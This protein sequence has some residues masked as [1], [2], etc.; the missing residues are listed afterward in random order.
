MSFKNWLAVALLLLA[1]PSQ[2]THLL[3]GEMS[4]RYLGAAAT[5][6]NFRY[7]VTVLVYVNANADP[8]IAEG[9]ATIEV[10]FYSKTAPGNLLRAVTIPRNSFHSATP[11]VPNCPG[12]APA[13]PVNVAKYVAVVE[14]PASFDGYY[15]FYTDSARNLGITN[16]APNPNSGVGGASGN[17]TLYLDMAPPL[18]PNASPIF[19]DTAVAVICQ[20]D[21]SIIINNAIDPDGDRL[22]YSFGTPSGGNYGPPGAPV[23]GHFT[24]PPP[25]INYAGGYSVTQ[26]FGPGPGNFAALNANTGISQYAARNAGTYVVA[27]DV[28]EYRSINGREVLV[29]R[30]RRDVQLITRTCPASG[31]SPA[32]SLTAPR[33]F[34]IEEGQALRFPI[35]ATSTPRT[36]AVTLK[37]NSVLLDGSSGS[38]NATYNEQPGTVAPGQPTGI[39]LLT[40]TGA[41]GA[42]F[43]FTPACGQARATPYDIVVTA[44]NQDCKRK[45][46]SDV[47]RITVT[48]APGPGTLTGDRQVC[49]PGAAPR[50]YAA[51]GPVPASYRWRVQGGTLLGAATGASVQVQWGNTPG[52]G[53]LVVTGFSALGCPTD[54][55]VALVDLR[56]APALILTPAAASICQGASVRLEAAVAGAPAGQTYTWTGGGQTLTGSAITVRPGA[57]TTYTVTSTAS[58]ASDACASTEQVTVTVAPLPVAVAGP[59]L[60]LCSGLSGQLGTAPVAG[61]QYRWSPTDGLSDATIANPTIALTN[62]TSTPRTITYIL[63]ATTDPGC[64]STSTVAVTV[65]PAAVATPGPALTLCSG[66]TGQLG[67]APVAGTT[68]LWS[69]ATGLSNPAIVNPTITLINTTN[70]AITQTY[71]L[72]ATTASGC[73]ATATVSITVSPAVVPFASPPIAFCSGSTAQLGGPAQA[74]YTYRWTPATG[75]SS[76]TVGNPTVTLTNNNDAVITQTYTLTISAP[77]G[78]NLTSQVTVA[79]NPAAVANAGLAQAVCADQKITLGTPARPGYTYLWSPATDLS[80]A[81]A[82]QPVLTARN[83]TATPLIVKYWLLTTTALGCVARDSVL[84]TINPRPAATGISGPVSVCPTVQGIVYTAQPAAGGPAGPYQWRVL[85]GEIASGQGTASIAVNWGAPSDQARVQIFTLN[86]QQCASDTTT[87]PVRV[88]VQLQTARPTGPL[89]VCQA[90]GPYTYQTS[91]T[92]GSAYSWTIVGGTQVSS[93]GATVQVRWDQPGTGQISVTETSN[94]SAG[95]RCLGQSEALS[96]IVLPS[97]SAALVLQGPA[98]ACV[99]SGDVSFT[100]PG[101]T[102]STYVFE[103]NGAAVP[104]TGTSVALSTNTLAPGTYTLTARE[105]NPAGCA[106]PRYSTTFIIDPR[107]LLPTLAG[108]AF[109]CPENLTGQ[110]YTITGATPSSTFAWSI[111]GG[112]TIT[113]G[114]GTSSINVSFEADAAPKT[115]SV[116]ETSQFGCPGPATTLTVRPDQA[117]VTLRYVTVDPQSNSKVQVNFTTNNAANNAQPVHILR[118]NAGTTDAFTELSTVPNSTTSYTDA[119]AQASQQAYDYKVELTNSCGTL[120]NTEPAHTSIR[121]AVTNTAS[122]GARDLSPATLTWNPYQGFAVQEYRVY[123]ALDAGTP[124][125]LGTVPA[126]GPLT[127]ITPTRD[128]GTASSLGLKQCFYVEAVQAPIAN[129]T[130]YSSRSNRECLD[131]DSKLAF[132]NVIT[133]NRDGKNDVLTIEN[134]SLYPSNTLSI[135]NRWGKQV[136]ETHDYR[137]TWGQD[138]NVTAGVYYYLFKQADGTLNKGWFEVVR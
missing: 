37:V 43:A 102:T 93:S 40:G 67:A 78:C 118:R 114:Q 130:A 61:V 13:P 77:S 137:N 99:N 63:T 104:A 86:G 17:M 128:P 90:D 87:L 120:L 54:S 39:V 64:Q 58:A 80:R 20:G 19:T 41:A 74:G 60:S 76:A 71:T 1:L 96:V 109:V 113:A 31:G 65:N 100:L 38:F 89:R 12:V 127:F 108:P 92:N 72:T 103:L 69:P 133:P 30:S 26:P 66:T 4:Y 124:A 21:T 59:A 79:V 15:A 121:L 70:A 46:V 25:P 119:T 6:G 32:L 88:N 110:H 135:F 131:V 49:V 136:Y 81:S 22:T 18:I 91:F 9:R 24:P 82:A 62:T 3:G 55:A 51:G 116:T 106:G 132:Y 98:R 105:T 134:V 112:G 34:T 75:L 14:L 111:A 29:G 36:T 16:I 95:V 35:E 27:V 129:A 68:Y 48:R 94:P 56:P 97:P 73:V 52:T 47:F 53:R 11:V 5:P 122:T 2:A 115:I 85:G 57:T 45:S 50:T 117:T 42:D 123:R 10:G 28:N 126:A 33:E 101:L 107:P 7:E 23:P 8:Q 125:L 44:T 84:V 138:D 83:A